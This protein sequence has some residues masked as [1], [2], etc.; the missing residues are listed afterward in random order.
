MQNMIFIKVVTYTLQSSEDK[1]PTKKTPECYK[2][3]TCKWNVYRE[4]EKVIL[5]TMDSV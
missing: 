1:E 5:Y 3:A 2:M 4:N